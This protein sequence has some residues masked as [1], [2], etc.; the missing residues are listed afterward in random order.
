MVLCWR[1]GS[2]SDRLGRWSVP[3]LHPSACLEAAGW[4]G[5][6]VRRCARLYRSPLVRHRRC[7]L[8]LG[9]VGVM[10]WKTE[11][12]PVFFLTGFPVF[13]RLL[14]CLPLK[15]NADP[16]GRFVSA[17]SLCV[18]DL[19]WQREDEGCCTPEISPNE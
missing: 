4:S 17:N 8:G 15:N 12:C 11:A 19:F 9:A 16:S 7:P 10:R 18:E 14:S 5:A 3:D 6:S 1:A 2:E 13:D